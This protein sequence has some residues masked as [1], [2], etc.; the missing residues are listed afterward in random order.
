[1]ATSALQIPPEKIEQFHKD[2]YFVLDQ[3][4]PADDLEMLR[5]TCAEAIAWTD[6]RIDSGGEG[7]S[8][9]THK[10]KRYFIDGAYAEWPA[11]GR[12]IFSRYMADLC[13][14]VIG[15]D[16]YLFKNQYVVKSAEVGMK[17]AWHQDS[18]YIAEPHQPYLTTWCPLDDVSEENGTVYILPWSKGGG[19][20]LHKHHRQEGTNDMVGYD[21][22]E[23]GIPI[24]VPAGGMAVFSSF[25]FHRSGANTTDRPRRVYLTAYSGQ[26]MPLKEG[27]TRQAVPFLKA[28]AFV[29]PGEQ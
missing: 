10:G 15:D 24:V 8:E 13:R 19:G 21:G 14:A 5:N 11:L 7:V 3:V 26:P 16:V 17:F 6:A 25:T 18:S 28:G 23:L 4:V 22:D 1:L 2:G 12:Y 27:T 9:I 20:T 29:G